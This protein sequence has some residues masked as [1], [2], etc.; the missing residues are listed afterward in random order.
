MSTGRD[1]TGLLRGDILLERYEYPPG[2]KVEIP[3][4]T[5]ETYQINLNLDLPGGYRYRGGYQVVPVRTLAV[6]M[7]GEVHTPRDCDDRD[8]VSAHLV[9]YVHPA[10]VSDDSGLPNFGDL[11]V[12]D[13]DLVRRFARLHAV[14]SGPSS[15]SASALDTD[16]RLLSVLTRLTGRHAGAGRPRPAPSAHRAVRRAQDYLHDNR[17]ANVSLAELADVSELSPFHLTRLFTADVGMPPHSYQVQL[18]IEHAKRL[19]LG[20]GSVSDAGHEAGFFDLSHFTRHFKRHV[21]VPPGSY[22]R[23]AGGDGPRAGKRQL[24]AR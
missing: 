23:R 22:A 16:V 10:M 11:V 12:D 14:L 3:S 17:A 13:P 5:H 2:P 15:V 18:R 1:V 7:P 19:L 24:T 6:I 21:G 4:H 8:R 20:G 9:L